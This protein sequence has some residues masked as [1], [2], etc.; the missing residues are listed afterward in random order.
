MR[1]LQTFLLLQNPTQDHIWFENR[2]RNTIRKLMQQTSLVSRPFRAPGDAWLCVL[3]RQQDQLVSNKK[4]PSSRRQASRNAQ[5]SQS[6]VSK[7]LK[8]RIFP[9]ETL[10]KIGLHEQTRMGAARTTHVWRRAVFESKLTTYFR[11]KID[12]LF[13]PYTY[14]TCR[15]TVVVLSYDSTKVPSYECTST[16]CIYLPFVFGSSMIS[17]CFRQYDILY[18]RT[19]LYLSNNNL[20]TFS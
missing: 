3:G 16:I 19:V 5:P 17:F 6:E 7:I 13:Y 14:S 2:L 9:P 12:K 15:C 11:T 8:T 10:S 18:T 20:L 4:L 1:N